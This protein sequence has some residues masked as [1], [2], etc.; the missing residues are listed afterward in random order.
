MRFTWTEKPEKPERN[1]ENNRNVQRVPRPDTPPNNARTYRLG[2][3]PD[4]QEWGA[5][6]DT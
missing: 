6:G 5:D 3:P 4:A 2:E 1:G